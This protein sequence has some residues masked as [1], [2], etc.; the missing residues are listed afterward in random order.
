MPQTRSHLDLPGRI[1][2][3]LVIL[4]GIGILLA[5]FAIAYHLFRSPVPGLGLPITPSATAPSAAGIGIA[6][7]DFARQLLLLFVMALVGSAVASKG[8]LLYVGSGQI[9]SSRPSSSAS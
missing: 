5:V 2:A 3:L 9:D 8:I 1:L 7:A 4:A 6:M